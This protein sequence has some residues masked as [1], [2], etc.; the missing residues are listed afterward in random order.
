MARRIYVSAAAADA[1]FAQR[2]GNDLRAA[3]HDVALSPADLDSMDPQSGDFLNRVNT[4]LSGRDAFIVVLSTEA[5]GSAR[6]RRE[7]YLAG[8]RATSGLMLAPL[9]VIAGPYPPAELPLEWRS[10]PMYDAT[11][12]YANALQQLNAAM[13]QTAP[14]AKRIAAQ[15]RAPRRITPG[16]IVAAAVLLVIVLGI[17]GCVRYQGPVSTVRDFLT[18]LGSANYPAANGLICAT[19][20][21]TVAAELSAFQ[22][23]GGQFNTNNLTYKLLDESL[24]DARVQVGGSVVLSTVNGVNGVTVTFTPNESSTVNQAYTVRSSG[25]GWCLAD[26]TTIGA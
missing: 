26:E 18:A 24:S 20:T 8:A 6:V 16:R 14:A 13:L 11:T 9:L 17:G 7:V 2:L 5:F 4:E 21:G 25:I 23:A 22:S 19:E 15:R 3:G 1:A 12:N 10:Y